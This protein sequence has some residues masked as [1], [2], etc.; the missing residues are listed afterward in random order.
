MTG[1]DRT[2]K[3]TS[4]DERTYRWP[5]PWMSRHGNERSLTNLVDLP[6]LVAW[7]GQV[8]LREVCFLEVADGWLARLKG[9]RK[10]EYLV[11]WV[12]SARY[13]D[14]VLSVGDH[15]EHALLTWFPD[16]FPPRRVL[17]D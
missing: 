14:L 7:S 4:E 9:T 10:G 12:S 3:R 6:Q 8:R 15:A 2:E 17:P 13:S 1:Q 5:F 16:E 11:A